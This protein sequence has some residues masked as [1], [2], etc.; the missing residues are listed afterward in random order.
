M[1]M[2]VYEINI[3][4]YVLQLLKDKQFLS[5]EYRRFKDNCYSITGV[6]GIIS[7]DSLCAVINAAKY[8]HRLRLILCDILSYI[9]NY[10]MS[11]RNFQMLLS[12]PRCWRN[13]YVFSLAHG[14]ISFYQRQ[15]L[16]RYPQTYEVFAWLFEKICQYDF[17]REEDMKKILCENPDI[18]KYGVQTCIDSIHEKYGS[19]NKLN[20]AI[21]WVK[22]ME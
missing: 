22:H 20:V 9:N 7:S 5:S 6:N 12:F 8:N 2:E 14:D 13:R 16:N 11:D 18:T 4:E 15:V 1:T 17:F 10:S 21:E 3:N 19:S